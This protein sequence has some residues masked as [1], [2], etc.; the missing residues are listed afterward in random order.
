MGENNNSPTFPDLEAD[1]AASTERG[2]GEEFGTKGGDY[3]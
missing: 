3:C 1:D 2:R